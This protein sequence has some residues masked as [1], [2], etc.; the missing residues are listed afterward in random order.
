MSDPIPT[1]AIHGVGRQEPG[2]IEARIKA[3]V[4]RGEGPDLTVAEFNWDQYVDHRDIRDPSDAFD[5]L[6]RICASFY[7]TATS[8]LKVRRGGLDLCLSHV[9]IACCYLLRR[10]IA[11]VVAAVFG[12]P[13]VV[14][15]V[16]L[17]TALLQIA[18]L[19]PARE[20]GWVT[21]VILP[22]IFCLA[23]ALVAM[24]VALGCLRALLGWSFAPLRGAVSCAVLTCLAPFLAILSAPLAISWIAIGALV[25]GISVFGILVSVLE[26]LL[27]DTPAYTVWRDFVVAPYLLGVLVGLVG[28]QALRYL[29]ARAWNE[30]PIK[31][32]LDI[33]RYV[34]EP[35]YRTRTLEQLAEFIHQK[36]GASENLVIV[37]HSLGT[38]IALDYLCNWRAEDRG[39]NILLITMGSPYRR[40]FLSWLPGVLFDRRA[41]VGRISAKCHS[42]RWLN[43]YRPWDYIGTSLRLADD[44]SVVDRSTRQYFRLNGHADY[45]SDDVVLSAIKSALVSLPRS[46]APCGVRGQ[47]YVPT[48]GKRGR[49]AK[50]PPFLKLTGALACLSLGWMSYSFV[51]QQSELA[52]M[53]AAVDEHGVRVEVFVSHR[54]VPDVA[55]DFAI[56]HEFHFTGKGVELPPY[57]VSPYLPASVAQQRLDYRQLENFVRSNCVPEHEAA[58]FEADRTILCRSKEPIKVAYLRSGDRFEF[59]LPDFEPHFYYRDLPAWIF[60]P[61]LDMAFM[62]VFAASF[63]FLTSALYAVFLGRDPDETLM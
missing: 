24:I 30:G 40:F 13:A 20:A 43:V 9:Q 12:I 21:T 14:I 1:I 25:G 59:Y 17:P 49:A 58:W 48:A 22:V 62:W 38:I 3:T 51:G 60:Y 47:G 8:V 61:L 2:E 33:T 41:T 37:A 36:Q 27:P 54:E 18:P 44:V 42:F 53:R 16:L 7:G 4:G 31:I 6:Q 19:W 35:D 10:L 29:L 55:G 46:T 45:W 26:W 15:F 57:Q 28:L 50:K 63:I 23:A 56:A 32:L 5:N 34:G 52:E 39:H 11:A